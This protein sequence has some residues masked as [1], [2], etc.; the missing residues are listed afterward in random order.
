MEVEVEDSEMESSRTSR[1]KKVDSGRIEVVEVDEFSEE[2]KERNIESEIDR[3][4]TKITGRIVMALEMRENKEISE[5]RKKKHIEKAKEELIEVVKDLRKEEEIKEKIELEHIIRRKDKKIDSLCKILKERD[6]QIEKD[7]AV[8]LNFLQDYRQW[9]SK[10]AELENKLSGKGQKK[11]ANT[12][13][14]PVGRG[15]A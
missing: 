3:V 8:L 14:G 15:A 6:M 7:D 9:E 4:L 11:E 12:N 2:K 13:P 10:C 5:E 1:S